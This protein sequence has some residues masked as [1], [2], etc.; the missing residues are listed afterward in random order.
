MLPK[1]RPVRFERCNE[2]RADLRKLR[3]HKIPSR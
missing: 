1:F 2:I 3:H